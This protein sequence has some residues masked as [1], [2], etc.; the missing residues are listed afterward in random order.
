VK[1]VTSK[2]GEKTKI[3]HIIIHYKKKEMQILEINILVLNFYVFYM[4]PTRRFIF[5][6]TVVYTAVFLKMNTG[7]SKYVENIK[8]KIQI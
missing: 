8:I 1:A 4:F 7:G 5:R 6:K 2:G 3:F